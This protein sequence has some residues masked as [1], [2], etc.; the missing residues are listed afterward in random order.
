MM[1]RFFVL[2]LTSVLLSGVFSIASANTLDLGVKAGYS[3][4]AGDKND[5]FKGGPAGGFFLNYEV[6]SYIGLQGSWL[7]HK[8]DATEDAR[9]FQDFLASEAIGLPA[10]TD[11]TL[12]INQF[13]FNGRFSYPLKFVKPYVLAGVGF[14]YWKI[15]GSTTVGE[16]QSKNEQAFW[17]MAINFGGGVSFKLSKRITIGGELIYTYIF[18]DYNDGFFNLMATLSYGFPTGGK[19][20]PD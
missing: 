12:T 3:N 14:D 13:D 9:A 11:A 4:L 5:A 7:L 1:K 17:D 20:F 8:H 18:D 2:V 19:I 6:S 10:L 15:N 16:F